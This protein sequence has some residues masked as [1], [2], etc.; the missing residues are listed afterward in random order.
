MDRSPLKW[1]IPSLLEVLFFK[2]IGRFCLTLIGLLACAIFWAWLFRPAIPSEPLVYDEDEVSQAQQARNVSFD[3]DNPPRV[4]QEVDYSEG[5]AAPWF[6]RGESPILRELVEQGHLPPVHERVGPEPVVLHGVDG[7]GTY[8]G[9]WTFLISSPGMIDQNL[10]H[11][12]SYPNL[13]RWTHFGYPMV[14]HLAREFEASETRAGFPPPPPPGRRAGRTPLPHRMPSLFRFYCYR[15]QPPPSLPRWGGPFASPG[16]AGRGGGHTRA[17][18]SSSFRPPPPPLPF[19]SPGPP[20]PPSPPLLPP[21]L[22]PPLSLPPSAGP[23]VGRMRGR[24]G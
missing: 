17:L 15:E 22:P 19:G 1:P 3:I 23:R 2:V 8:G 11:R 24:P 9:S 7:I 12:L 21:P 20:P 6:P 16:A 18:L 4:F 14:P 5:E 10:P 13:V